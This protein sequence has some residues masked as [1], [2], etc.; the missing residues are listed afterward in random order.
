[1]PDEAPV[2]KIA[3]PANAGSVPPIARYGFCKIMAS[4]A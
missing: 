4:S 3:L 2:M 1:M